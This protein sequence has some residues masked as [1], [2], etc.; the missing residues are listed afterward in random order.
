MKN[1]SFVPVIIGTE[2]AITLENIILEKR[3]S[4]IRK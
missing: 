4:D 1:D 3:L 2:A